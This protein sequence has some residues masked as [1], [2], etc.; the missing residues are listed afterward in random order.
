[1]SR[2]VYMNELMMYLFLEVQDARDPGDE[3]ILIQPIMTSMNHSTYIQG[4]ANKVSWFKT[5]SFRR[6]YHTSEREG[7]FVIC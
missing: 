1:M 6:S 5:S 2:T 4:N 7:Q 3:I